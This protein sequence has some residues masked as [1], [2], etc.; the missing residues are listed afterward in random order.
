MSPPVNPFKNGFALIAKLAEAPVQTVFIEM[1]YLYLGKRWKLGRPPVFPVQI[2][3][4]LG[5]QFR[6][7]PG[8]SAH[9]LGEEIEAYFR[10][11]MRTGAR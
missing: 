8:Q 2:K 9:A 1:S 6:A 11:V 10:E 5:R 7:G 3:I 4:R